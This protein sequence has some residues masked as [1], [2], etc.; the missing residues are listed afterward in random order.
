MEQVGILSSET[1]ARE[2]DGE[3]YPTSLAPSVMQMVHLPR[4]TLGLC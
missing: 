3:D 1:V 4:C 2:A